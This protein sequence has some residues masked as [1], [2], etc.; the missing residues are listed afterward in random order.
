M[1]KSNKIRW[2][3]FLV[4]VVS[5]VLIEAV[6]LFIS[7]RDLMDGE[8]ARLKDLVQSRARIIEAVAQFDS[9]NS[10]QFPGGANQATLNQIKKAHES[11]KGFGLT[12]EFTLARKNKGQIEFLLEHRNGMTLDGNS[13][14]WTSNLAEPM[15]KALQ[16][17]SG[18]MRGV[19]YRGVEVLSAF[20][21]VSV[22]GLGLV[23]KIDMDEIHAPLIRDGLI[24]ATGG[25]FVVLVGGIIFLRIS[26]PYTRELKKTNQKLEAEVLERRVQEKL[27][28][29][30]REQYRTLFR[31]VSKVIA[32]SSRN[33]GEEFFISLVRSLS[34]SLGFSFVAIAKAEVENP[35][36]FSTLAVGNERQTLPNFS[37]DIKGTP[38]Q[39]TIKN[40]DSFVSQNVADLYPQDTWLRKNNIE[41]YVGISLRDNAG[42]VLGVLIACNHTPVMDFSHIRLIVALFSEMAEAELERQRYEQAFLKENALGHLSKS[43]AL[44][45]NDLTDMDSIIKFSLRKICEF[46]KWPVGH[47]YLVNDPLRGLPIWYLEDS[48]RFA[49]FKSLTDASVFRAGEG[50]PGRILEESKAAWISDLLEDSNFPRREIAQEVG[51][52]TGMAFPIMVG[53]EVE[54]VLEF[55]VD[56]TLPVNEALMESLTPLGLQLGRVLERARSERMLKNQAQVLDQIHDAVI[57][58]SGELN[59]TAWNK[60]AERLFGYAEEEMLGRPFDIVFLDDETTLMKILIQP[61]LVNNNYETEMKAVTKSG[62]NIYIN[63]SLS[64]LCNENCA[65][66]SII[67][68]ALDITDRKHARNQLETYSQDLE[69]RVQQRTA[70][71]NA[72][73]EKT[74]ESRD[75]VEGILKSIEEGLLV[76]DDAEKLVLM[77]PAAEKILGIKKE[78]V[79]GKRVSQVFESQPFLKSWDIKHKD[80]SSSRTFSFEL[81][82][83]GDEQGR[84]F[85]RGTSTLLLGRKDEAIGKVVVIADVTYER[86]VDQLKSQFLS[87]AAHEL[88]TP[89]TSLQG[90]SEILLKKN[91]L[92]R[93]TEN[94]Y[95]NYINEESIKLATIINDFL[96]ISRIE[97][98]KGISLKKNV[99]PAR[100]TIERSMHIFDEQFNSKHKFQ[101]HYP[102]ETL[103]WKVDQD[104]VEQVLKNIYSNAVKYSPNGGAIDTTIN[105]K[106]GFVRIVIEDEGMGMSV[107]QLSKI[108]ERFY[109][110]DNI[111]V[112]IPGSGLGMTI[113]KYIVEAHG[114]KISVESTVGVGTRV[115]ISIPC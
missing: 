49:R 42:T 104:K 22:L 36:T 78:F 105:K 67:C 88:R 21:P 18:V 44:A 99:C 2:A 96:D 57:S 83:K 58:I 110:A 3:L 25:I 63:I 87:T 15:R 112:E 64:A 34:A 100:E 97:S 38:C 56:K 6:A 8:K 19:D 94:K 32:G 13:V 75:Q 91:N 55:F 103:V 62:R 16:G 60:G 54:G 72:S 81:T 5:A 39:D 35:E 65:P 115:I 27:L 33:T 73:I 69:N 41:A 102:E 95:L 51:L 52:R 107:D 98:D 85:A 109:R 7:Y 74:K 114:G 68:Y 50:L 26:E 80:S 76:A 66:E 46:I 71:L 59:I 93:E 70:E 17:K 84:K 43:I 11:F 47:F 4:L 40:G 53:D 14:T 89:L 108:Y 12:G 31:Q 37:Y 30:S 113:V 77:N 92:G 10:T 106:D 101:F 20:E 48:E 23:A 82:S 61:A 29:D 86:K 111:G 24:S 28:Q 79:L 45:S 1:D 90:F 9:Q